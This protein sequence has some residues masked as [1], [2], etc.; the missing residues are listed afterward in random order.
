M[1][2]DIWHISA[3]QP[4]YPDGSGT[5]GSIFMECE[6]RQLAC[7]VENL[8]D[9]GCEKINCQ[10][11]EEAQTQTHDTCEGDRGG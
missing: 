3:I 5:K 9:M 7:M 11:K 6:E 1:M 10:K 2:Y 8:K 4:Q